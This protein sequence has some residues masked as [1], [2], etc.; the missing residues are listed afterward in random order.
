MQ[1]ATVEDLTCTP[2]LLGFAPHHPPQ[3]AVGANDEWEPIS[4]HR[5]WARRAGSSSHECRSERT[6]RQGGRGLQQAGR[7]GG[8][9]WGAWDEQR[10]GGAIERG[11]LGYGIKRIEGAYCKLVPPFWRQT[12]RQ[13]ELDATLARP[14][15]LKSA[16]VALW[17]CRARFD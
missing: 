2:W 11:R 4:T 7:R 13:N 10:E 5:I 3:S 9:G 6:G 16:P 15:W 14:R 17:T 12:S 8:S 1:R